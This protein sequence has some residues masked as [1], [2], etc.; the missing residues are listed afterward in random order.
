MSVPILDT[1]AWREF[2]GQPG[3]PGVNSTHLAKIAD[4][5]GKERICYVKLAPDP[6]IPA[7][8]CEALGWVLAGHAAL[9]RAEF[10]AIVM[11]DV[12]TLRK[13]QPLPPEFNH[14]SDPL[15]PAWCSQAVP[16]SAVRDHAKRM[17]FIVSR[18]AFLR[19]QDSRKFAAFDH[20]SDLRDR[21]FGNVIRSD[22]GYATIDHETL[23]YDTLWVGKTKSFGKQC[24]MEQAKSA[25][26]SKEFKR[27]QVDMAK[28]ATG[29]AGALVNAQADLNALIDLLLPNQAA[30]KA[31]IVATL[32]ARSQPGWLANQLGVIA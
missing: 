28:A 5:S 14:F 8:L 16:G 22:K 1:S 2:R 10:V 30:A 4:E 17:D 19:S 9:S 20:W 31:G 13:S 32:N 21:N 29:H 3:N 12:A 6:N 7:L 18:K 27:F 25:L 15:C 26:D 23:L 24:L 11:V